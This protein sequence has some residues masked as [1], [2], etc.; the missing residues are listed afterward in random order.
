M[1]VE[2]TDRIAN[3]VPVEIKNWPDPPAKNPAIKNTITRN[4]ILTA[5]GSI[6][7]SVVQIGDYEPKRVRLVLLVVDAAIAV[8]DSLPGNTGAQVSSVTAKP[9]G[10]VLPNTAQPYEFFGPDALWIINLGT[11]TRV[12]MIKEYCQ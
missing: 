4:Y 2:A 11:P 10:A 12:S 3:P 1:T 8:A 9:S 7:G 5:D 6:D